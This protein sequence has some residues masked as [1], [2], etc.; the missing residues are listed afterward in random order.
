MVLKPYTLDWDS[1]TCAGT[2]TQPTFRLDLKPFYLFILI[3]IT[4]LVLGL[5]EVQVLYVSVQKVFSE[6]QSDR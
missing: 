6:R 2:L 1:N 4:H 3:K 5:T